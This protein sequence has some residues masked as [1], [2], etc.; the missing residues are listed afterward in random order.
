DQSGQP[1]GAVPSSP[2]VSG[3][4]EGEQGFLPPGHSE[5]QQPAQPRDVVA[6]RRD[7][8]A[9]ALPEIGGIVIRADNPEDLKAILDLIKYIQEEGAKADIQ[10][11][12]IELK[13]ADATSVV[14]TLNQLYQRVNV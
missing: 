1:E 6:P 13:F 14:T 4:P 8:N 5:E 7:V 10:I 11:Q 3:R 12:L 9:E 2:A